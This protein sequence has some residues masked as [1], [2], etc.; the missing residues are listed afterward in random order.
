MLPPFL[1]EDED[2]NHELK[3]LA[4][5]DDEL[6]L[7]GNSTWVSMQTRLNLLKRQRIV[8]QRERIMLELQ[9][10]K[11]MKKISNDNNSYALVTGASR[12]LGRAISVELARRQINLV[13]VARDNEKLLKLANDLEDYYDVKCHTIQADLSEDDAPQRIFNATSGFGLNV[14]ILINNAG[15]STKTEFADEKIDHLNTVVNVNILSSMRLSHLYINKMRNHRKGAVMFVSSIT[16]YLPG[17]PSA[18]LYAATKAFERSLALGLSNENEKNGIAVTLLSP[19]AISGTDFAQRGEFSN[20]LCWKIPFYPKSPELVAKVGIDAL[21]EG[22]LECVPGWQN[23]FAVRILQPML[24]QKF[25]LG[26]GQMAWQPLKKS[27]PVWLGGEMVFFERVLSP[28]TETND[29]NTKREQQIVP[30][31]IKL[32]RRT[33]Q[34]LLRDNSEDIQLKSN[35]TIDDESKKIVSEDIEDFISI[36]SIP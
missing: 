12:G 16:G 31:E 4:K 29:P 17:C 24:P 28:E 9:A 18:A 14:D 8:Q 22:K 36:E 21:S 35:I 15:L 19:G 3:A 5:Y 10:L 2:D 26:V 20:A 30:M 32:T 6:S 13:L 27:L 33:P 25:M 34:P 1:P 11:E 23:R 7:K